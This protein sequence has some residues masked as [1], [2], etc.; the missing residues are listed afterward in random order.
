MKTIIAIDEYAVADPFIAPAVKAL[1]ILGISTYAAS[2]GYPNGGVAPWIDI[3]DLNGDPHLG[4]KICQL[5]EEIDKKLQRGEVARKLLK[6]WRCLNEQDRRPNLQLQ[7]KLIELLNEFYRQRS[8]DFD[9]KLHLSEIYGNGGCRLESQGAN[10][11]V[12]RGRKEQQ[13][14]FSAYRQEMQAFTSFLESLLP[15]DREFEFAIISAAQDD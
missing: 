9:T 3:E 12:L 8:I 6:Q 10:V 14:R 15:K 13:E 5:Q 1:A 4:E 2:G 7:Q 11:Q